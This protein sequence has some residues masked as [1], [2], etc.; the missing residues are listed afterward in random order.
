MRNFGATSP[1]WAARSWLLVALGAL[2][3]VLVLVIPIRAVRPTAIS[4]GSV[5]ILI[6][7]ASL[8][9]AN[10]SFHNLVPSV[11]SW[12][13]LALAIAMTWPACRYVVRLLGHSIRTAKDDAATMRRMAG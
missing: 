1:V 12:L 8:G 2:C 9:W 3:A 7:L 6:I 5:A 10:S 13:A 11:G 4:V